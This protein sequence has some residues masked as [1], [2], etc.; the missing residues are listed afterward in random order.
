MPAPIEDYA[1]IGDL[2]TSALVS[3][4]G[5]ID[6][7]CLPRLDSDACFAAL[8]GTEANGH[9]TICPT[10]A[11]T[12]TQRRYRDDTLILETTLTTDTGTVRLL[13]FMP[14]REEHPAIIRIVQ[15]IGGTVEMRSTLALRFG[16]GRIR[17]F[18]FHSPAGIHAQAGPDAVLHIA[19]G[20]VQADSG[21]V[22]AQFTVREGDMVA[23]QSIWYRPWES[24]PLPREPFVAER[25]TEQ[26]WRQWAATAT[27]EGPHRDEVV[28]S[29][30]TLKALTY[31]PT[32]AVAAAATTSL[33]EQIGGERNWDYRYTWLRD[34]SMTLQVLLAEGYRQEA[35]DFRGWVL[36]AVAG[37][38]QDMQ[39]MYSLTGKRHLPEWTLDWLPGY[40]DSRPVRIGNGAAGQFQL[41]VY[42]ELSDTAYLGRSFGMTAPRDP[43]TTWN[44]QLAVARF[45]ERR[46]RDPDEGI[47]EVRGE[48]QHFTYS[49]VMAWVT[50]D[51]V[52]RSI[53]EFGL[54]GDLAH[55]EALAEE[56]H[57]DI[58]TRGL[59]AARNCFTQAYGSPAMDASLL[60]MPLV[61]FLPPD[62]PR[63]VNTV[64]E[65]ERQLGHQ[66]LL[67][68]YT[69][70][71]T[72]DGLTGDE[73][74]FLICS[75]WLVQCLALIGE[76]DRA[77]EMFDRL[78]SLGNDVGL[79]SEE[80]DPVAGRMLGNMPQAFS[81]LGLIAAAHALKPP[82]GQPRQSTAS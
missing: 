82:P 44:L 53:R 19:P 1:L 20:S 48:P 62:D 37:D 24:P 49:K 73:G 30:I 79:F 41:D 5:S 76:R 45:V 55:W 40:E 9:W 42:G 80:Y 15:G 7:L 59:D 4:G 66:G 61:G 8:L 46:W 12:A 52:V 35:Y 36:R 16:Y 27:Y 32:G 58:C 2:H 33:P 71:D 65:V 22:V 18:F 3:R 50:I 64:H 31:A 34:A 25:M 14:I 77:Q 28:R 69:M 60:M 63:M 75:F 51:R 72:D 13:D 23:L 56:I 10:G 6:W 39:I 74:A 57:T 78:V 26:W 17:P 38:P 81:H 54:E 70:S 29:L 11:V 43:G 68:R 67:L 21:D 47:W